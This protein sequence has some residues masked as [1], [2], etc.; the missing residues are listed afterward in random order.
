MENILSMMEKLGRKFSS[1]HNYD[2]INALEEQQ[3]ELEKKE[4]KSA[5]KTE[6]DRLNKI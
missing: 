6:V 3:E 1:L 4:K 5:W 2:K